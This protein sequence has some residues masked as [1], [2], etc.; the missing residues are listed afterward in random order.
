MNKRVQKYKER[1][2]VHTGTV[3]EF[4]PP[5]KITA[6]VVSRWGPG[7]NFARQDRANVSLSLVTFGNATFEQDGRRGGAGRDTIFIAHK[8]SSHRRSRRQ[9]VYLYVI[10]RGCSKNIQGSPRSNSAFNNVWPWRKISSSTRA[11]PLSRWRCRWA[12]RTPCISRFNSNN[13]SK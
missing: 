8:G 11:N 9:Q 3:G 5:I 6:T 4:E 1:T 12:T 13:I 10:A 2:F 7:D